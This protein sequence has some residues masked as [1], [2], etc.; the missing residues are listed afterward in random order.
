MTQALLLVDIQNDYFEGGTFALPQSFSASQAAK[1]LLVYFRQNKKPVFHIQHIAHRSDAT[2]FLPN[3]WGAEIH[4]EVSPDVGE[5]VIEKHFPNSFL[6]TALQESLEKAQVTQLVIAGMMT[7][8]CIDSTTRA[9]SDMGYDCVVASDACAAT[10]LVFADVVASAQTVHAVY[11]AALSA[12]FASVMS[13]NE[14]CLQK[15]AIEAD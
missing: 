6:K 10:A 2:F 7:H 14:I 3:S 9:A 15:Q 8:M 11:L 13:A 4:Q 12:R 1:R 5:V